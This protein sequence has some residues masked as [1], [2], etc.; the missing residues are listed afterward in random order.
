[1]KMIGRSIFA[2]RLSIIICWNANE[3]KFQK[4]VWLNALYSTAHKKYQWIVAVLIRL[5]QGWGTD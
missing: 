5:M 3:V 4:E 1:M 2:K